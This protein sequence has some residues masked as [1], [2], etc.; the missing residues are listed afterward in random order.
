MPLALL[1]ILVREFPVQVRQSSGQVIYFTA[2]KTTGFPEWVTL[3][4][5]FLLTAV[6]MAAI[7]KIAADLFHR[8]PSLDSYRYDLLGSITGSVS[9]APLS[10]IFA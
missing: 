2:V 7:G 4:A 3:P 9:F 10:M 1:V 5:I 8:L 6:I